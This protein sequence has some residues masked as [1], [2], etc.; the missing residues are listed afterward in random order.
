[1]PLDQV[2]QITLEF[3]THFDQTLVGAAKQTQE[4]GILNLKRGIIRLEKFW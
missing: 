2:T 3:F 4:S 1:M